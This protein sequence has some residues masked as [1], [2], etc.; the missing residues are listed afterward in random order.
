MRITI[1]LVKLV[2]SLCRR[3]QRAVI[4]LCAKLKKIA[5]ETFEMLKSVYDEECLSRTNVFEWHKRFKAQKVRM[6]KSWVKTMLT[7][8][9]ML[10]GIIHHEIVPE[11]Q[12]VNCEFYKEVIKRLSARVH[13]VKPEF[14]ES[15]SWYLLHDNASAHFS[16]IFFEFLVKQGIPVLSHP[17]CSPNLVSA[18][19]FLF[20][21]LK[22]VMEGM[23][24]KAVSSIQQTV[25]RELKAIREEA[26]SRAF[27]SLYE[28]CK[29]YAESAGTILSDGINKIVYLFL[30]VFM[31]LVQEFNCYTVY[32][33]K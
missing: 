23:R 13:C 20:S 26:F 22:N 1:V 5:T 6:Q 10:K 30:C 24:F 25:T 4:K 7:A 33:V 29:R 12:T 21:E 11:R 32:S 3:F 9:L 16:G 27:D 19:L 31:D 17:P 8:Y 14:Q 15:G 28:Q 2:F 18:D